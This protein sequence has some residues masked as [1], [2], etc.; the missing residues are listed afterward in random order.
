MHGLPQIFWRQAMHTP[1]FAI[2]ANATPRLSPSLAR[3]HQTARIAT[4]HNLG[5][6]MSVSCQVIQPLRVSSRFTVWPL[7]GRLT[8]K[9][10]QPR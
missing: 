4:H 3:S 7:A 9:R 10:S 1:S 5:S 6:S 2:T 8:W